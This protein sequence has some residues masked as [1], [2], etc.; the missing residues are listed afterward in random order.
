[1]VMR[2]KVKELQT[3]WIVDFKILSTIKGYYGAF[4]TG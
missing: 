1:M 2:L 3:G 4:N